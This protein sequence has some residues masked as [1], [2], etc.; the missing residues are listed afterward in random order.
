MVGGHW[1]SN[2]AGRRNEPEGQPNE[3]VGGGKMCPRLFK[4]R[5]ATS[6]GMGWAKQI[7]ERWKGC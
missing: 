6:M 4:R 5:L 3:G 2:D 7:R 1:T